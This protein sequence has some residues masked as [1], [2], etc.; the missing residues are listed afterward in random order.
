MKIAMVERD[1][2]GRDIDVSCFETFGEVV[3]YPSTASEDAAGNIADADI[4]ICNKLPIN[5]HT[6]AACPD[7]K[8]VCNTAT[9]YDNIDLEYCN[10]RG[11]TV[12]NVRDYSTASVAQHTF[13]LLFYVLEKLRSYDEYVKSGQYMNCASFS[14][15]DY[16]FTE[17]EG[18]TWGIVGMG[19]IGRKVAKIAEAFGCN[20]IFYSASGNSTCTDYR[21]VDFD[22]LLARSDFLSLHCPLTDRTRDLM[23]REAFSK[24]KKDAILINVARGPVVNQEALYEA[25]TEGRIAAAGLDV[26][27]KEPM[28]KDNPLFRLKDSEKLIITP[29][30]AWGSVEARGRVVEGVYKNIEAFL[31]GEKRNVVNEPV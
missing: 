23:D 5:A 25:L 17:L 4:V 11:I 30:M 26:L 7:I 15:F 2:V 18:R 13:A 20:V 12:T 8:L 9:G 29:H 16:G 14:Y 27:T 21:R 24:M 3:Y 6:I 28:Q 22:T 19:N 1:S 10:Q 31:R